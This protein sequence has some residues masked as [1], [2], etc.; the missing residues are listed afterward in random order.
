M[1]MINK[2]PAFIIDDSALKDI[3]EGKN[4]DKSD[5]LLKK[6]KGAHDSGKKVIAMTTL[7][8]FLRA[9][10]LSDPKVNINKIQK[11]LSF[12][13]V[14]PSFADFKKGKDVTDEIIRFAGMVSRAKS[15]KG[16]KSR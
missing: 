4:K 13:R 10:Y 12:M 15:K 6:L 7:S 9:I 8:A 14:A 11:M 2:T 5:D 3:F 1:E 16:E